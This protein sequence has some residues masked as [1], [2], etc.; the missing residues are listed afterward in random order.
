MAESKPSRWAQIRER[1]LAEPE[2]HERYER[3]R[4]SALLTHQLL[5]LIDAEREKAGLTKAELASRIG[6]NPSAVRRLLTSGTSNPT[7]RTT[8]SLLDVLGLELS[9]KPK[10]RARRRRTSRSA[11]N[12]VPT[13]ASGRGS[14][15]ECTCAR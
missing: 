2:L 4:R 8:L 12:S 15:D 9:V 13:A 3:T 10:Q 5:Q 7:L 1:R 11:P 6:T 14:V